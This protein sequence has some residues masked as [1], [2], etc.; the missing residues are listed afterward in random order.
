MLASLEFIED[1]LEPAAPL[2][3]VYVGKTAL[4]LPAPPAAPVVEASAV[5]EL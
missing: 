5:P 4:K 1:E 3:V 2:G